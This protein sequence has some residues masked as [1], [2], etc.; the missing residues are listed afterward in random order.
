M[1]T[2]VRQSISA[3]RFTMLWTFILTTDWKAKFPVLFSLEFFFFTHFT[4]CSLPLLL[5]T[6]FHNP[7][8]HLPSHSPL[9]G[10]SPPLLV[11]PP[12]L[13]LQV[14]A[15]LGASSPTEARQGSPA[16]RTH[17]M[18]RQHLL[19][20]LQLQLFRTNMKTKLHIC[21]ICAGVSRH[22]LYMFFGWWFSF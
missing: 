15:G 20:Y 12:T 16:R 7:F 3:G 22:S 17:P 1:D 19:R 14:S 9:R 4:T 18:N 21:Y 6:S 10:W 13:A 5:V 11:C 2:L 8:P